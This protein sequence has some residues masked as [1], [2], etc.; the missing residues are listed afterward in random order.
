[1]NRNSLLL[2]ILAIAVLLSHAKSTSA[3]VPGYPS[4]VEEIRYRSS[5][6]DSMQ[7][8][9]FWAPESDQAV[10]LLVALHTWSSSFR[11]RE[12]KYPQWCQELG[13]A[14]VYPNFRGPNNTPDALGSDLVVADI[15][16]AVDDVRRRTKIDANRI[17]CVGVSGGGHASQL[18]AARAPEIGRA[19]RNYPQR[20]VL[21]PANGVDHRNR[22]CTTPKTICAIWPV[23]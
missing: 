17:Y 18:I 13:W 5:G 22:S 15:I 8:A 10:P 16:S 6:D 1:M 9:L 23:A 4:G 7:P 11:S 21:N 12:P 14:Y 3:D 19:F 20:P 2:Y